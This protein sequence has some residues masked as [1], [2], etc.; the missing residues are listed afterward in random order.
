MNDRMREKEI[1]VVATDVSQAED[2]ADKINTDGSNLTSREGDHLR[3]L[4]LTPT[5]ELALQ[6]KKHIDVSF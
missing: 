1:G 6:I 4:I 5:R 3:A 2:G